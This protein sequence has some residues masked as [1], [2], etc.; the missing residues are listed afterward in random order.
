MRFVK[1]ITPLDFQAKNVTF[2]IFTEFQQ[3]VIRQ[4]VKMETMSENG[5]IYTTNKFY[6]A[7]RVTTHLWGKPVA[8]LLSILGQNHKRKSCLNSSYPYIEI[9]QGPKE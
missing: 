6:T 4:W 8:A 1:N 5:D 3:F 2:S 9:E 7:A